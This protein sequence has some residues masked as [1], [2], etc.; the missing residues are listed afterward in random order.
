MC[1]IVYKYTQKT[2]QAWGF[3]YLHLEVDSMYWSYF[4]EL[5]LTK[6]FSYAVSLVYSFS[7]FV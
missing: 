4:C 3:F 6:A 2:F 5:D 1:V 7:P